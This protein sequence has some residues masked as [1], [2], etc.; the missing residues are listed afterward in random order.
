MENGFEQLFM[1]M[2]VGCFNLDI[3]E[4]PVD[5]QSAVLTDC[6]LH[7]GMGYA[8]RVVSRFMI[9]PPIADD[10]IGYALNSS[11]SATALICART[12]CPGFNPRVIND[13]RVMLATR[14]APISNR[15]STDA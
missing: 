3:L 6:A 1:L 11:F 5:R 8:R 4:C 9:R 15:T 10:S 13:L 7:L 12:R 14:G 2:N